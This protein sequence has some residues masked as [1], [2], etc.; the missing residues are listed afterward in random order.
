MSRRNPHF[1]AAVAMLRQTNS[2]VETSKHF[3]VP[4]PTLYAW[5]QEL[6]IPIVRQKRRS[7]GDEVEE[8]PR[9]K[10]EKIH[11]ESN[12]FPQ[13]PRYVGGGAGKW[14]LANGGVR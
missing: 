11:R 8:A 13:H 10:Y 5:A 12:P 4:R 9:G 1:E 2:V 7:P 6:N 3:D 14:E